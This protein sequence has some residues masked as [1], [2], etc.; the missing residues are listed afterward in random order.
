MPKLDPKKF[1]PILEVREAIPRGRV[2]YITA[3]KQMERIQQNHVRDRNYGADVVPL[4]I[5]FDAINVDQQ[6]GELQP[7]L[8]PEL[9]GLVADTAEAL[10]VVESYKDD[11]NLRP[12]MSH[13][14]LD[15]AR[16]L[17]RVVIDHGTQGAFNG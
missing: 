10:S 16:L 3:G 8:T 1:P 11:F 6:R 15:S 17:L 2:A 5:A 9:E 13:E 12:G 4:A 7:P 14:H